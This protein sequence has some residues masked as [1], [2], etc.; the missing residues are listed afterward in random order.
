[1]TDTLQMRL[2]TNTELIVLGVLILYIA[3]TPGFPVVRQFLSTPIGKAV[4]LA[5]VVYVWKYVSEPVALLLTVNFIRCAGM[6]EYLEMPKSNCP[7]GYNLQ[8]NVCKKEGS[9]DKPATVCADPNPKWDP[10]AEK[11]VPNDAVITV[12]TAG[13]TG[14]MVQTPTTPPV[15]VDTF[16]DYAGGVQPTEKKESFVGGEFAP[17]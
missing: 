6:R 2:S 16:A 12:G 9:P 13:S 10:K 1:M 15:T 8:N 7:E 11:G 17:F 5:V 4:G 3:F 14:S